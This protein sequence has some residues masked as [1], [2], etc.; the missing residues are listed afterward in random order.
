MGGYQG[1]IT[2]KEF[3]YKKDMPIDTGDLTDKTYEAI[4]CEAERFNHDLTLQF[5]LLSYECKDETDYILKSKQLIDEML[6]Y[7]EVDLDDMFFGEP[8]AMKDFHEALHRILHNID[9]LKI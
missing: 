7:D 6:I 2:L 9:K 1:S 3:E 4:L 8:P 5:G